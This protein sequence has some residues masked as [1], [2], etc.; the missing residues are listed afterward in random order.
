MRHK[1][2]EI[3]LRNLINTKKMDIN[4]RILTVC[5]AEAE[6]NMFLSL[7]F[8]DVTISNFDNRINGDESFF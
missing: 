7:G 5:A 1:F 4:D 2:V 8:K 6:K 3:V